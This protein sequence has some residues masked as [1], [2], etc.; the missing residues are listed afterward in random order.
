MNGT[1]K[2]AGESP[3]PY[4]VAFDGFDIGSLM[5]DKGHGALLK[6][7]FHA[8]GEGWVELALHWN[9]S[10][11]IDADTGLIASGPVISLLDNATG[12]AVWQKRGVIAYQATVDLRLDYLR[13]PSPGRMLIGRGECYGLQGDL[14]FVRGVAYEDSPDDPIAVATGTYMQIEQVR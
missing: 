3:S 12:M 7:R 1:G 8:M 11:A 14:A 6:T 4:G 9:E 2:S 13:M 5:T 10:I